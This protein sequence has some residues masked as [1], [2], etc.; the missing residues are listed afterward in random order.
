[1]ETTINADD[2]TDGLL[3]IARAIEKL[4]GAVERLGLNG[5]SSSMGAIEVLAMEVKGLSAA[6]EIGMSSLENQ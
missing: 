5:A 2:L 4:A 6:L 1:M 3:A